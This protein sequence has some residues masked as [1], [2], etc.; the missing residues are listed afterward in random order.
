MA[1]TAPRMV[2][3]TLRGIAVANALSSS[4]AE[5]PV[6]I[7]EV[8]PGASL[9]FRGAPLT[10]VRAFAKD[11]DAQLSLLKWLKRQGLCDVTA[12]PSCTSHFVAA[13]AAAIAAADWAAEKPKWRAP[14]E[15]PWHPYDFVA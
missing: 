14:A 6:R 10:A 15:L 13:C 5:H 8:H 2:Y 12:P 1:P 3:L 4:R 11:V 7:V 9:C